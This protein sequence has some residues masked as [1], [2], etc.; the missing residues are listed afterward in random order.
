MVFYIVWLCL[1]AHNLEEINIP[2]VPVYLVFRPVL[3]RLAVPVSW[4]HPVSDRVSH[5]LSSP[6]RDDSKLRHLFLSRLVEDRAE[7]A[8]SYV[9]FLQH[10]RAKIR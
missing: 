7:S 5:S 6:H 9:E 1:H 3:P 10:I 4:L 8:F 2:V